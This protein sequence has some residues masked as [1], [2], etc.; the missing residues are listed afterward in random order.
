MLEKIAN[1][2]LSREPEQRKIARA[3]VRVR[4]RREIFPC[5]CMARFD[6]RILFIFNA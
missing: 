2:I 5:V 6:T 4:Q 3:Y 1:D